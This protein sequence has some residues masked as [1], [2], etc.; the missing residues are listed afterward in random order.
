MLNIGLLLPDDVI[1]E[2]LEYYN[3]HKKNIFK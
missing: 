1:G 2:V 3:K